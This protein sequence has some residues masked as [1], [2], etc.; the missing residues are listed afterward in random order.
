MALAIRKRWAC[1][2]GKEWKLFDSTGLVIAE[3]NSEQNARDY[4]RRIERKTKKGI[5]TS[6]EPR[7]EEITYQHA[8]STMVRKKIP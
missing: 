2:H 4:R 7:S 8:H 6:P 3:F 1:E 5:P